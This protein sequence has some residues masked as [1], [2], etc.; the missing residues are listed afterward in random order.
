MNKIDLKEWFRVNVVCN[1]CRAYSTLR[2][3]IAKFVAPDFLDDMYSL[4]FEIGFNKGLKASDEYTLKILNKIHYEEEIYLTNDNPIN[5][6]I[7]Y[8]NIYTTKIIYLGTR[9]EYE[10]SEKQGNI[11]SIPM[12]HCKDGIYFQLGE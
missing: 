11:T 4:G 12:I 1:V 5:V 7:Y 8:E 10:Q 9:E 2:Y 6:T 3:K